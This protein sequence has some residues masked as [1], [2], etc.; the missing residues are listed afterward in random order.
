[1]I[2]LVGVIKPQAACGI[3][4]TVTIIV[5]FMALYNCIYIV[6]HYRVAEAVPVYDQSHPQPM[7]F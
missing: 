3:H 1:M 6:G 5:V 7:A 4:S 2:G